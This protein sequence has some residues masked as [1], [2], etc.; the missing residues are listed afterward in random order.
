MHNTPDGG[1]DLLG[2]LDAEPDVAVVVPDGDERL[3]AGALSGARLLLHRHDLQH[4]VLEGGAQEEVDDL[5]LLKGE[6]I[7]VRFEKKI[8]LDRFC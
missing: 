4:V 3:E 8:S 2:A 5:E 6:R 7:V 1:G